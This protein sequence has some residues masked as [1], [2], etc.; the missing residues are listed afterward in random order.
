MQNIAR[1][2]EGLGMMKVY[3]APEWANDDVIR[4]IRE[5]QVE[6]T[7][8]GNKL[9]NLYIHGNPVNDVRFLPRRLEDLKQIVEKAA[10]GDY[11]VW[12]NDSFPITVGLADYLYGLPE[13]EAIPEL[14]PVAY[15]DTGV[16]FRV[17]K[18]K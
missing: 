7:I 3:A 18:G 9:A 11:L 10:E 15:L 14:E 12:F 6:G 8:F 5:A 17:I 2:N 4:F 16:I 13:L 1:A